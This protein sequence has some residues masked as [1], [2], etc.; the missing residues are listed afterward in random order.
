MV[1]K[2]VNIKELANKYNKLGNYEKSIQIYNEILKKDINNYEI[3]SNRSVTYFKLELYDLALYDIIKVIKIKP[4]IGKSWGILG[5]IL[6]GKSKLEDSLISYNK[7]NELEPLEIY[8]Q[9]IEL[10]KNQIKNK[11][12]KNILINNLVEC[13]VSNPNIIKKLTNIILVIN[14]KQLKFHHY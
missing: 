11:N 1:N 4:N 12:N 8:T 5:G 10:I 3:L 13:V 9:M 6:Y 2:E 7:A 14:Q